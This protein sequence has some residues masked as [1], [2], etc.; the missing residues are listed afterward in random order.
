[1]LTACKLCEHVFEVNDALF[2][3]IVAC[4]K[5]EKEFVASWH[6]ETR[7][8]K[9]DEMEEEHETEHENMPETAAGKKRRSRQ[10]ILNEQIATVEAA[11]MKM[12]PQINAAAE[13]GDNESGTRMLLDRILIEVL[14]YNIEDIKTEQNIQG[15]RADY[16][17]SINEQAVLVIELKK[18]GLLLKDKQV[19][20]AT[21]YG[22]YAGIKWALLTNTQVWKL[23]R[24]TLDGKVE[25]ELVFS[26]DFRGGIGAN[27]IQY[28]FLLS[29]QGMQRKNVL[30][31]LWQKNRTLSYENLV[32]AVLS[33]DVVS[34]I[35]TLLSKE[36]GTKVSN[37][38]VHQALV[39]D[40]LKLE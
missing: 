8:H 39:R 22:A 17:V 31:A 11:M 33:D 15:R 38:E 6:V 16:V 10:N 35:R 5:C 14:G 40:V 1:M 28:L 9:I 18:I 23:Y 3:K 2:G 26:L 36:T 37:E 21:S 20:Q 24:V 13:R 19:F 29:K 30:E 12:M 7:N 25:A 32:S 34:K 27:S 4:P